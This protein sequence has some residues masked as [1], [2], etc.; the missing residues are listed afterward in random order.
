VPAGVTAGREETL[1][2][3][4]GLQGLWYDLN[5]SAVWAG[6]TLGFSVRVEGSRHVPWR[7]PALVV[8]NHESFLDPLL[9]GMAVVRRPYY[10]ARK[11][12]FRNRLFGAYLRSV[13]CVPVDQEG[14]AKE[15]LK[16]VLG[17]LHAGQAVILFPEGERTGTGEMQPLRPGVQLLIKRGMAPVVPVGVAGSFQAYSRH[18]KL[19]TLS[20]LFLPATGAAVAVSVGRPIDPHR[21]AALPRDV[22][23]AELEKEIRKARER[24]RRL[25]RKE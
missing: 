14:V 25:R 13:N 3:A 15:G 9:V 17:L 7:G 22:L 4:G 19:P 12:L 10:L 8:A 5:H 20:P 2:M 23:L 18:Q 6:L 11:T 24:A 21:L 1:P 16:T